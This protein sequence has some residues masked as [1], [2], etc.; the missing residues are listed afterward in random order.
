MVKF[1]GYIREG[2]HYKREQC[3]CVQVPVTVIVLLTVNFYIVCYWPQAPPPP[4][5]RVVRVV[6]G[7][8]GEDVGKSLVVFLLLERR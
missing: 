8:G 3:T 6:V 1:C 4:Q 5:P 7:V 2:D